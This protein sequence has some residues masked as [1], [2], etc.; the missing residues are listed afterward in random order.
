MYILNIDTSSDICSV[1]VFAEGKLINFQEIQEKNSHASQLAPIT[2]QLLRELNI[3]ANQLEAVAINKG[4]G[5]YT[6]L[7]IGTAFAKG[8]CYALNIPLIAVDCLKILAQDFL[9]KF[10][11][12]N[13]DYICP[14]LDARRM[15]VYTALFDLNLNTVLNTQAHILTTQSFIDYAEKRVAFIG[16]GVSKFKFLI[17]NAQNSFA[18]YPEFY[19]NSVALGHLSYQQYQ[20][21]VF[22]D[23][24]YFEPQ[25]LKD[26]MPTT[27]KDKFD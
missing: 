17:H 15:E 26:F 13:V 8:L 2:N 9:L 20:H 4:P 25:Y 5:S 19:P 11:D 3:K 21:K 12:A 1:S 22:E 16:N 27:P 23:I 10:P 14:M 6:G 7:R 24:A 18:F